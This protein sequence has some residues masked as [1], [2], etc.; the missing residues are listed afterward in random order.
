MRSTFAL[1]NLSNLIYNYLNIK[2][3]VKKTKIMAVV[4]ADAY[5]HG[6][7]EIVKTLNSIRNQKP[8]YFAVAFIEEGV[9]LRKLKAQQPILIFEPPSEKTDL[10]LIS[11]NNLTVTIFSDEHLKLLKDKSGK[12][13]VHIKVDTGMHRLG[14]SYK[15]AFDY[16]KKVSLIKNLE[17]DGIYSHFATSDEKNKSFAELQFLR[18]NELILKLKKQN[19]NYGLAHIANS[20]AILDLPRTYLDMVRPGICLYGYYPSLE[21]SESIKLKPVMNLISKVESI[22]EINKGESVS[23][24]RKFFSKKTIKIASVPFGYAD[25]YPRNLSNKGKAIINKK[26][27]NQ[28]GTV[29]MDR[30]MFNLG[31][32]KIKIGNKVILLGKENGNE[33]S[34]WDWGKVLNTIPYEITCSISNRVPRKYIY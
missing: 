30:I 26:L 29:T 1:I 21:T 19:I 23:Y 5:G 22:K 25:G 18:F 33:I 34:A 13:K 9:T 6:I 16:I 8:D 7:K 24:G 14:I 20:G 11:K 28:I 15:E 27:Y 3:K 31:K 4:K 17:I 12:T 10:K 2:K 32:D